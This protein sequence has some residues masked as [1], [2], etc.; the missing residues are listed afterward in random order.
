M[1][2]GESVVFVTG[3]ASGL[4][5]GVARMTVE[6]GGQ[7]VIVDLPSSAGLRL[8]QELGSAAVFVAAD[9]A[10]SDEVAAAVSAAIETFGTIHVVVN[11]AGIC[12]AARV[13]DRH[14]RA[15]SLESFRR[16]VE[17][18]LIGTFDVLRQCA[19][20]MARNEPGVDGERGVIVNVAS[21]AATEGQRG[22]AAYASS[23]AGVVGLAL[24]LARD[25]SEFGV[26]VVTV[27]PGVMNTSML[28]ELSERTRASLAGAPV[29]PRRLGE[30]ADFAVLVQA[31]CDTHLLNGEAI[32]LDAGARL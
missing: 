28:E 10:A 13:V 21:I 31:I 8:A 18:N 32:R 2:I 15:C 5:E 22:Q 20:V 25:L 4:G 3:G 30:A 17:V 23:K 6:A 9:V 29:F 12:P 11:C 27:S 14:G 16:A 7:V 19:A 24:P 26:R 1:N